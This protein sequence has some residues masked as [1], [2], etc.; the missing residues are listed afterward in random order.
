ML[1]ISY[2][3]NIILLATSK[4]ALSNSITLS[5]ETEI[6]L[7]FFLSIIETPLVQHFNGLP[8]E[9]ERFIKSVLICGMSMEET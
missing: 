8:F 9:I 7:G 1:E 6:S 4:L 5:L 3:I 2:V